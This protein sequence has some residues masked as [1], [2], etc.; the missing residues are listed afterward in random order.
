[1]KRGR[2]ESLAGHIRDGV[3]MKYSTLP[4][5]KVDLAL[6]EL[7]RPLVRIFRFLDNRLAIL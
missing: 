2:D 1:M 3:P 4:G 7:P 6:G 5:H